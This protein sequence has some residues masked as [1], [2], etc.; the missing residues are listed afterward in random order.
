M[1]RITLCRNSTYCLNIVTLL[2]V[3]SCLCTSVVSLEKEGFLHYQWDP[4][5]D[6]VD[7][8][9][10]EIE[11]RTRNEQRTFAQSYLDINSLIPE[12]LSEFE[13]AVAAEMVTRTIT[14]SLQDRIASVFEKA[15]T[16]ACRA[17]IAEH[18]GYYIHGIGGETSTPFADMFFQNQCPRPREL[19]FEK[20]MNTTYQPPRDEA[21]YIDDANDLR[22]LYGILSHTSPQNTIRLIES[23]YEKG[24]IFVVHVDG[25][26]ASKQTY[27]VLVKYARKRN[28]VHV[29]PDRH[30]IRV[31]WGGYSMVSTIS[32]FVL[33][34]PF[35]YLIFSDMQLCNYDF[36]TSSYISFFRKYFITILT[37]LATSPSFSQLL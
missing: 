13:P 21:D 15:T 16:D 6:R 24:H 12:D 37:F 34:I 26:E 11:Y 27:R 35:V 9:G 36:S 30:R 8:E 7:E 14:S 29:V 19:D 23:L 22:L 5:T 10:N 1:T 25:K 28:H 3:L 4:E 32:I 20:A 2:F 17:K 31:N 33:H 18:F